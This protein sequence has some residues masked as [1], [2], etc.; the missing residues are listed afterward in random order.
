M[1]YF[2]ENAPAPT[3]IATQNE[4]GKDFFKPTTTAKNVFSYLFCLAVGVAVAVA[5]VLY[6]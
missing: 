5:V 1:D 6:L 4:L 2:N 3:E